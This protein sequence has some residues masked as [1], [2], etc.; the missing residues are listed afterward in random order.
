MFFNGGWLCGDCDDYT[1][2][3]ATW[4]TDEWAGGSTGTWRIAYGHHPYLSNGPHGNAGMYEGFLHSLRLGR[5]DQGLHGLVC[6]R[7]RGSIHLWPRPQSS[8]AIGY[9]WRLDPPDGLGC[10]SENQQP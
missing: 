10:W 8:V 7:E 2:N 1:A 3:M 6:V 5:R 9:L 4:L